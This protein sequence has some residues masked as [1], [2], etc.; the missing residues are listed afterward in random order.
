M[1]SISK[2]HYQ[3]ID[4]SLFRSTQEQALHSPRKRSNHNFHE[5]SEVYQRFLNVLTK[6]TY[7][8]PHR[9]KQVPKPE[10]FIALKGELGFLLFDEAGNITDQFRISSQGPNFGIDLQPGVW[11]SLVC[12]TDVC[13]CF[14]G[15]SGP[16]NPNTDKEF[17]SFAPPEGDPKVEEMLRKW[18]GL[19]KI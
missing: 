3:L 13:V 10:T 18:E 5:L 9:H 16:Y 8:Q 2:P 17:A 11:H 19:F 15:K 7:V 4:E 12:L 1:P 6:G 14:E